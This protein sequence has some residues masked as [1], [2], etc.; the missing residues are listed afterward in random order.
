[1]KRVWIIVIIA[2]VLAASAIGWALHMRKPTTLVSLN[3]LAAE[4]L[5]LG[6]PVQEICSTEPIKALSSRLP[7]EA[8]YTSEGDGKV[9]E[10]EAFDWFEGNGHDQVQCH[11]GRIKTLLPGSQFITGMISV[12]CTRLPVQI[13]PESATGKKFVTG[14]GVRLGD[15]K[16]KVIECYGQPI[17]PSSSGGVSEQLYYSSGECGLVFSIDRESGRVSGMMLTMV[18]EW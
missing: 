4:S 7:S 18:K 11:V 9:S 8:K 17:S 13:S 5:G 16:A 14:K 12:S 1:M 15:E 10:G 2:V 3:E 6:I